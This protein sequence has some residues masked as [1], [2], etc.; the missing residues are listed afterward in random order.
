MSCEE[1]VLLFSFLLVF[2][3]GA[4]GGVVS[5]WQYARKISLP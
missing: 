4:I 1:K 2:I 3:P 5:L